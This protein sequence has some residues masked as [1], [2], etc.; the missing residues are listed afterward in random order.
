MPP[1]TVE[2][3]D[4]DKRIIKALRR[5]NQVIGLDMGWNEH[6]PPKKVVRE[7]VPDGISLEHFGGDPDA[8]LVFR[9][10]SKSDRDRILRLA[11]P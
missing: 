5:T 3:T 4:T 11:F 8:T 9:A 10:L 1:E 2:L 6:E 7:I